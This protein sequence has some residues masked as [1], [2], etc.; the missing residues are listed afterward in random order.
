MITT[1]DADTFVRLLAPGDIVAFDSLASLSGLVQ[2]CDEAPV[3]HAA[4][5]LGGDVIAM[6]NEPKKDDPDRSAVRRHSLRE[7][8]DLP[9]VR[10]AQILR[11]SLAEGQLERLLEVT[12]GYVRAGGDFAILQLPALAPSALMRAYATQA[13]PDDDDARQQIAGVLQF[14]ARAQLELIPDD[15]RTLTCSEFVYRCLVEAGITVEILDALDLDFH[16]GFW[17]EAVAERERRFWELIGRRSSAAEEPRAPEPASVRRVRPETVT[18]G[19]LWR[20]P[21]LEPVGYLVKT[22]PRPASP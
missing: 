16:T 17:A 14:F 7:T 9:R 11:P 19:D 5:A 18:P 15:A 12:D 6:A 8:L 20:S 2:W 22:P 10:A 21:S 13:E 3:N 4:L 1:T